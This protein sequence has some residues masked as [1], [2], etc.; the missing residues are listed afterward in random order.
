M[1]HSGKLEESE[2]LRALLLLVPVYSLRVS[3]TPCGRVNAPRHHN[4]VARV[5]LLVPTQFARV[6]KISLL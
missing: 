1:S 6:H 5:L 4:D 2:R 3:G